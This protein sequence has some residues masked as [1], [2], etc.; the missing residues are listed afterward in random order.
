MLVPALNITGYSQINAGSSVY[1]SP[2]LIIELT[3]SFNVP[4]GSARGELGDFF[5]FKNYGLVHGIGFDMS[6]KYAANKSATLFPFITGGFSHLQNSDENLAY[7]DSNQIANGYPLAGNSVF[8]STPGSSL[9]V[10]KSIH[11]GVGLQYTV[12]TQHPVFP[13]AAFSFNYEYIWGFYE[14]TPRIV[15]G[16]QESNKIT[17][18]NINS[19][20]RFGAGIDLGLSY[21]ITPTLGFVF[22]TRYKIANLFGKKSEPTGSA[23]SNPSNLNT[24]NLLDQAAPQLN[25]NLSDSRN[26]S[27]LQFYIGFSVFAGKQ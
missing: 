10:F 15:A 7:I 26:L 17:K 19:A 1:K 13:F 14:Q 12:R 20:N 6:I 18:F 9:L 11:I 16:G 5:K 23:S 3:G 24:M 21:R 27:Y 25:S 4:I 8:N 2:K 22:G